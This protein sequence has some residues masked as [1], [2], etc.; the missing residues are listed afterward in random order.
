[1]ALPW[2]R[3]DTSNT[4]ASQRGSGSPRAR[5][6]NPGRGIANCPARG[7]EQ[8]RSRRAEANKQGALMRRG[9][10]GVPCFTDAGGLLYFP[11]GP[12]YSLGGPLYLLGGLS[13]IV[14]RFPVL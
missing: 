5:P 2:R 6:G 9:R 8:R 1:M 3:Q 10:G 13:L 4:G 14:G 12:L 7:K 11:G